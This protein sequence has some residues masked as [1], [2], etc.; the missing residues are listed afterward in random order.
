MYTKYINKFLTLLTNSVRLHNP[1]NGVHHMTFS[2]FQ[3]LT[4][5][6]SARRLH[7]ILSPPLSAIWALVVL[8]GMVLLISNTKYYLQS[9]GTLPNQS[10]GLNI[11]LNLR[12]LI[13]PSQPIVSP[14]IFIS[15]S[16]DLFGDNASAGPPSMTSLSMPTCTGLRSDLL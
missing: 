2:S 10:S 11:R 14:L 9:Y 4:C 7:P 15:S 3:L 5:L 12:T 16:S 13:L 8:F 1:I 6:Y